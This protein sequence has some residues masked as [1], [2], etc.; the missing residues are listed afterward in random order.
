MR[1]RV[2]GPC[3]AVS[4][5]M[6]VLGALLLAVACAGGGPSQ[7]T[8]SASDA[9]HAGAPVPSYESISIRVLR[10]TRD[11]N[12]SEVLSL[13]RP[14][15]ELRS[16]PVSFVTRQVSGGDDAPSAYEQRL[17]VGATKT[18]LPKQIWSCD[19]ASTCLETEWIRFEL[20]GPGAPRVVERVLYERDPD[21]S[22]PVPGYRR[23]TTTILT[24][25][26][27]R[28][29]VSQ[30]IGK[31]TPAIAADGRRQKLDALATQD[32]PAA[33]AELD[34][35]DAGGTLG[36][37]LSLAFAAESDVATE[38]LA[39][40]LGIE[41]G[42]ETPRILITSFESEGTEG[43]FTLSLDLR[44][45]E[46]RA[47]TNEPA[48]ARLFQ[49]ARGLEESTLEATLMEKLTGQGTGVSTARLMIEAR[50]QGLELYR[51]SPP[52][53]ARIGDL[54]APPRFAALLARA[55]DEGAEVVV[56]SSAVALAGR[57]RWGFWRVEPETG[58]TIGV[59]EGGQH[60]G[61]QDYMRTTRE[62]A[63]NP[64]RAF[65]I[66]M[67]A[68]FIQGQFGFA[69]SMLKYGEIGQELIKEI[70]ALLEE[71]ACTA[72]PP[73]SIGAE[74]SVK[75]GQDCIKSQ[76]FKAKSEMEF[77]DAYNNGFKCAVGI[78]IAALGGTNP[79][80]PKLEPEVKLQIGCTEYKL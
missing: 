16:V 28:G 69:G 2:K 73:V 42:R 22:D 55:L 65:T 1:T 21:D 79:W 14:L 15:S 27:A 70:Q 29:D 9:K 61:M 40:A 66:G 51:I 59:M 53:R 31:Q 39:S 17:E 30:L 25:A 74:L 56:P 80:A 63:L 46:V 45:D 26:V 8:K 11:G 54:G 4:A 47:V 57:R 10:R 24:D 13:E 6:L 43:D 58:M 49:F 34:A 35:L 7:V 36:H 5:A 19:K 75:F 48:R 33:L 60:Q 68:G 23:Y 50:K 67:I 3:R 52:T 37:L 77:C 12:Q 76:L 32:S 18:P 38:R 71:Q 64:K 78:L 72:C 41:V 20:R 62:V 44:L